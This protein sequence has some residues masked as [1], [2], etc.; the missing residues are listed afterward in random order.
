MAAISTHLHHKPFQVAVAADKALPL[1]KWNHLGTLGAVSSREA[2]YR[3]GVP[4]NIIRESASAHGIVY[5]FLGGF[6]HVGFGT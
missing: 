3:A 5:E 1:R 4:G 6:V 2:A